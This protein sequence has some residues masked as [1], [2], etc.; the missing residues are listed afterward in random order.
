MRKN[1]F[2]IILLATL[3]FYLTAIDLS[4]AE[5]TQF[6]T[7]NKIMENMEGGNLSDFQKHETCQK[8]SS[9]N[10]KQLLWDAFA[11]HRSF[12]VDLCNKNPRGEKLFTSLPGADTKKIS[13]QVKAYC[14]YNPSFRLCMVCDILLNKK[15]LP[16]VYMA[17]GN[18]MMPNEKMADFER[19]V[20]LK[21]TPDT[22]TGH[23][24]G[25]G[26]HISH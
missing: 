18:R 8:Y 17:C 7:Q 14:D 1:H 25:S 23:A 21:S 2:V 12:F 15:T 22:T 6:A 11:A 13:G 26:E 4:H 16:D 9:A 3:F 19:D 5:S 10:Y 20:L 24:G